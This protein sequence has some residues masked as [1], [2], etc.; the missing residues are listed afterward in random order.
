MSD[1]YDLPNGWEW[2]PLK[3]ISK[4]E[5]GDRGKNYPSK[6]AFVESGIAVISAANLD[7]WNI[8]TN[9][10]NYI[11]EDRYDLIGSGKV[12]KVIYFFV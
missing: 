2:K 10:L 11:T 5:N 1:L 8:D 9:G 4:F 6:S 7:G 12:K 3:N